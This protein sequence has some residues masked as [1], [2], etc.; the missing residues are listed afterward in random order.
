MNENFKYRLQFAG[1][2]LWMIFMVIAGIVFCPIWVII[3]VITGFNLLKH[4]Q[5]VSQE[6]DD[7][8]DIT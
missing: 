7:L 3:W 2:I 5:Y 8:N 1:W 6:I 4:L